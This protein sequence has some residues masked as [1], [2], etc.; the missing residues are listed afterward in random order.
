MQAVEGFSGYI[1]SPEGATQHPTERAVNSR[2]VGSAVVAITLTSDPR[3]RD[4]HR[5]RQNVDSSSVV[6]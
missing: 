5:I 1:R 6:A 3:A 4:R 2:V